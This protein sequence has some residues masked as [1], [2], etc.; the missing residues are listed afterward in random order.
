MVALHK[1]TLTIPADRVELAASA[2]PAVVPALCY[3]VT[4][5]TSR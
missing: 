1:V 3:D 4:D 2:G 5:I